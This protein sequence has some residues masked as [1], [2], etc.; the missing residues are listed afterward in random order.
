MKQIGKDKMKDIA[1]EVFE[2]YPKANKVA[3]TSDGQAFIADDSDVA[4]KNHAQNN[5]YGKELLL[6]VF[7]RETED[8]NADNYKPTLAADL[9]AA[10]EI[11]ETVDNVISILG[12]D[13]RKTV[14]AA[15]EKRIAEIQEANLISQIEEADTEEAVNAILGDDKR[16]AVVAVATERI[17]ALKN[18]E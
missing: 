5:I 15:A 14:K 1:Q 6:E 8:E 7:L 10:I 16:E 3:V 9:I 4:A 13:K 18:Q 11:A 17:N 12:D 2:Q